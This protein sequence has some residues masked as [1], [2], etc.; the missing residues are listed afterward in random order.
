M[1][2]LYGNK[3]SLPDKAFYSMVPIT[4]NPCGWTHLHWGF[5][6][7]QQ[8]VNKGFDWVLSLWKCLRH[9]NLCLNMYSSLYRELW[10]DHLYTWPLF[11]YGLWWNYQHASA[12]SLNS[13]WEVSNPESGRMTLR[14]STLKDLIHLFL[15]R[16]I[17]LCVWLSDYYC[18]YEQIVNK[19]KQTFNWM[20]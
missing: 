7:R 15:Q 12:D 4:E 19:H 1:S 13:S 16:L 5:S 8:V 17:H 9:M 2:C 6:H 3:A 20:A 14:V 10:W 18:C 11:Q